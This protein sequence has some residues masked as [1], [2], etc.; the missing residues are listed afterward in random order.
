MIGSCCLMKIMWWPCHCPHPLH[1]PSLWNEVSCLTEVFFQTAV[2][3]MFTG[4]SHSLLLLLFFCPHGLVANEQ[5]G[6]WQATYNMDI[7][8]KN[9]LVTIAEGNFSTLLFFTFKLKTTREIFELNYTR[10][11]W[12]PWHIKY[13]PCIIYTCNTHTHTHISFK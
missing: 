13:V 2:S 3:I 4:H 6:N 11:E 8:S 1:L 12:P 10:N 9:F 7:E 5:Q